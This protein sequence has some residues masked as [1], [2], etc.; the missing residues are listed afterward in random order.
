MRERTNRMLDEML[1]TERLPAASGAG[2]AFLRALCDP[3]LDPLFWRAELVDQHSAWCGH[4]PFAHW[5]I[6]AARPRLLV[7]LGT[8]TGVSYSAF[9]LAV[10]R[11]RLDTRCYA[12]DTWRGD[13]HAGYYGDEVF[14]TLRRHHNERF[15]AFSTLLRCTFDEALEFIAENSVDLLHIDGL[16]TYEAVRHDFEA[17]QP[18][19]SDR[20]VVLFHDTNERAGDFG[21]WRLWAELRN[22]YPSFEFLHGHGLG[23]LAIGEN[24]PAS[25]LDLCNIP[26]PTTVALCATASHSWETAGMLNSGEVLSSRASN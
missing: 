1:P 23:V 13:E 17:W 19:L 20:A 10:E 15:G 14:E 18:K 22:L 7:E 26:E 12:I 24:A 4:I 21:V 25:I 6:S 5:I 16:H 11:E 9:C 3:Q 8:H 2:E